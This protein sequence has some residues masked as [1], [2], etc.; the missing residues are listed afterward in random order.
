[1]TAERVA[2][3]LTVA[4][5]FR[6]NP[7]EEL[8]SGM[9]ADYPGWVTLTANDFADAPEGPAIVRDDRPCVWVPSLSAYAEIHAL[10]VESMV[11]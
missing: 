9:L 11:S 2:R 7:F 4:F 8:F 1:M 10:T 5:I 6:R 3:D